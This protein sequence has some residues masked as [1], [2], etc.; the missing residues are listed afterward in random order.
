MLA[1]KSHCMIGIV[2]SSEHVTSL[3]LRSG[4]IL[5]GMDPQKPQNI[6]PDPGLVHP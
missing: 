6:Q 2:K 3:W 5:H 1:L 4:R